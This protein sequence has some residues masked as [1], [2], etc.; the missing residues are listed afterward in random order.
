[1]I[2][3]SVLHRSLVA[4]LLGVLLALRLLSPP[5]FM[6]AFDQGS[7][8]IVACPDA[9]GTPSASAHH[10]HN[11]DPRKLQQHC[12]Y[13]AAGSP[14]ARIIL[15]LLIGAI[16]AGSALPGGRPFQFLEFRERHRRPPPRGPPLPA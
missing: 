8:T 14:A 11:G 5:G 6:P 1:M 13:A 3:S 10:H 4:V 12:P 16:V 2:R 9:D 7:V 15:A